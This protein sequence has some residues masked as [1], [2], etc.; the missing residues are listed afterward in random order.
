MAEYIGRE[1][2]LEDAETRYCLPCKGAG[3]DY[4][5]VRCR[6]CWV[7]D[8]MG[9]VD[10]APAADVVPVVHGRFVHTGPR[11]A[12]GVDWWHCSNCVGLVSGAE[13]Q[14]DYCPWC[15]AKMDLGERK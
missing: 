13:T 7:N 2:F 12:G 4:N 9:E 10:D 6:A 11:F 3:K 15:G 8:M 1:A 14:F 5:G